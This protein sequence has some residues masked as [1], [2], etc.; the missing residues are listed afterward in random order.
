VGSTSYT[1]SLYEAQELPASIIAAW[2]ELRASNPLLYSPYFHPDYTIEVGK[3]L[4]DVRVVVLKKNTEIIAILPYQG[5]SFA[6]PVGAPLTD[7]HGIICAPDCSASLQDVLSGTP[8]GAFHYS[9]LIKPFDEDASNAQKGVVMA[10]PKG[11]QAWRAERDSSFNKHQKSLRRRIRKVSDEIG[12]PRLVTQSHNQN[13]FD[14]LIKWKVAQYEESG[15]YNVLGAEWTLDLLKLL[16]AK[17]P[18]APLRLDMHSLYFGDTLAAIDTGLTDGQTYHSWIVAY[19]SQFHTYSPGTQ[20]LNQIIDRSD[21]LGYKRIDLGVGIDK[22]KS[23]YA[24]EN[25]QTSSGFAAIFGPAAKLSQLYDAAERFGQKSLSDAPGKLRRRYSQIAAC[26]STIT[27]RAKAM[28][29]A[30]KSSRS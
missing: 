26:D 22:F 2:H 20:L 21:R 8:V 1:T 25:V 14:Q 18:E 23:Y 30:V 17:G 13:E 6:R 15:Y 29:S 3:R 9:A 28:L 24:T 4:K 7:Y 12:V 11:S 27:G 5:Q 16:W 19:D 10:F